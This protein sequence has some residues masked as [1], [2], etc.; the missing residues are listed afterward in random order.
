VLKKPRGKTVCLLGLTYKA[1]TSTLRHSLTL[2]IAEQMLRHGMLL[3]AY[4]PAIGKG[5]AGA[6]ASEHEW[7]VP[8]A[9]ELCSSVAE[10]ADGAW[11]IVVMTDKDEFKDLPLKRLGAAMRKR[12]LVDPVNFYDVETAARAGFTYIALGKGFKWR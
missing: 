1:H 10:A 9:I 12:V 8:K 3:R 4:D 6:S 2:Q 11:A 7:E 5:A